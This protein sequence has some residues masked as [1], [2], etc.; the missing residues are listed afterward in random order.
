MALQPSLT[1]FR[2]AGSAGAPRT[3]EFFYCFVCTHSVRS[4]KTLNNV[5][6][7][8][9]AEKWPDQVK[10]IFRPQVQP[11]WPSSSIAH[12]VSLAVARVAPS[13]WW[14]FATTLFEHRPEFTDVPTANLS[15]VQLRE[16]IAEFGLKQGVL[17][18]DEVDKVKEILTLKE[19][20]GHGV[21]DELKYCLKYS[22]Q[23]SVHFSPTVLFDGLIAPEP[24]SAWGKD[25]WLAFLEKKM[26][27]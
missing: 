17:T 6:L 11:W 12:E 23:N 20:G 25:E 3:L 5:I 1:P 19:G 22:R 7:P 8:L 21:T 18:Q 9:L 27:S 26:Q 24:Q 2:I 15:P 10:V 14:N 13:K 16:A 4:A